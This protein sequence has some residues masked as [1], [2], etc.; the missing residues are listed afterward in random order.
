MKKSSTV[1]IAADGDSVKETVKESKKIQ[2]ADEKGGTLREIRTIEVEKIKR[3]T[4]HYANTKDLSKKERLLEKEV[5]TSKV[6]INKMNMCT[7][8]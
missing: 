6:K 3:S 7:L 2:W 1:T 8:L 5:H 4:A